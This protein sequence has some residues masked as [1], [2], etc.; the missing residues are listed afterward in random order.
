MN[1]C[2]PLHLH[3]T[4]EEHE[5]QLRRDEASFEM[6]RNTKEESHGVCDKRNKHSRSNSESLVWQM[7]EKKMK[8]L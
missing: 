8:V 5:V 4:S 3:Y 7:T 1:P 2:F 6:T